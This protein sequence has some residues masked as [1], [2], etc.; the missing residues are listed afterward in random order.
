MGSHR[1]TPSYVPILFLFDID[2][3]QRASVAALLKQRVGLVTELWLHVKLAHWN[4]RGSHFLAYHELF[5]SV[6]SHLLAF[7]DLLAERVATLG[8][9][10][11][12]MLLEAD[13]PKMLDPWP[14]EA[15]EE[16]QGLKLVADRLG[17]AANTIRRDIEMTARWG[18]ADT[19]DLLTE[20]SRQLDK[21]LWFLEAHLAIPDPRQREQESM[22][23]R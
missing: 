13:V 2:P 4:V 11:R 6:A 16:S 15:H 22:R 19:A 12:L 14:Q 3:D 7:Q 9:R 10:A 5:D 21:D 20:V 23:G 1:E 8:G 18:D 17:L